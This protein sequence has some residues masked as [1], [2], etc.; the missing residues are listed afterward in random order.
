M[1][2]VA[3][4]RG[5]RPG[6]RLTP[7]AA[8]FILLMAEPH[9][10]ELLAEYRRLGRAAFE[11]HAGRFVIRPGGELESVEGDRVASAVVVEFP[12]MAA[13]RAFYHSPANQEAVAIRLR[14]V[15]SHAVLVESG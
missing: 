12:T 8:H 3:L 10:P 5:D 14:A 2:A 9:R 13:A 15:V 6:R 7:V 11:G 1:P 4:A